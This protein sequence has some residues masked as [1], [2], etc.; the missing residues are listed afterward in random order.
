MAQVAIALCKGLKPGTSKAVLNFLKFNFKKAGLEI[1]QVGVGD[2]LGDDAG[3]DE[4]GGFLI[5]QAP[6]EL[7]AAEAGRT[8][9][10]KRRWRDRKVEDF[11]FGRRADFEGWGEPGFFLPCEEGEMLLALVYRVHSDDPAPPDA[12][13]DQALK[14]LAGNQ[15]SGSAN[16]ASLCA[17]HHSL[18]RA[19]AAAGVVSF[20]APLHDDAGRRSLMRSVT[21][22][23]WAPVDDIHAY[24]GA[25]VGVAGVLI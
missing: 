1:S 10:P 3:D 7:L 18:T 11:D 2:G 19:L 25:K 24:F 6:L 16:L 13:L 4:G 22:M 15:A 23:V 9:L 8:A 17:S 5:I 14:E 12:L 21:A 20:V